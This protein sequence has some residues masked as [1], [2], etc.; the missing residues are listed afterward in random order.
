MLLRSG[1]QVADV[2]EAPAAR[3]VEDAAPLVIAEGRWAATWASS[4][5]R[6]SSKRLLSGRVM[7]LALV[8][9]VKKAM[10]QLAKQLL[11]SGIAKVLGFT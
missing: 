7:P 10:S 8:R 6:A 3:D 9:G 1:S 5:I 2:T 4:L 11:Y